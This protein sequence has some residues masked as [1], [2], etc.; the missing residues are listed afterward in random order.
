M[1][2]RTQRKAIYAAMGLTVLALTSGF[3]LASVSLGSSPVTSEQGSRTTTVTSVTGLSMLGEANLTV[4]NATVY[5]GLTNCHGGACDVT[6]GGVASCVG[7][8]DGLSH[9]AVGDYIEQIN[10]TTTMAVPFSGTVAM[11][12]YVTAGGVTTPGWTEYYTDS[13][14]AVSETISQDFT[15]GTSATGPMAVTDVTIVAEVV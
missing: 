13:G 2:L 11:T 8:L 7:A 12:M 6:D 9:C 15:V 1:R 14:S 4:V 10:S 5:N 3:A